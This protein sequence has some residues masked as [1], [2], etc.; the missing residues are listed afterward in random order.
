MT[1][2]VERQQAEQ[3]LQA[4]S[5]ARQG[6]LTPDVV[7]EAARDPESPLHRYFTWDDAEAGSCY[8]LEQARTLIRSVKVVFKVEQRQV[9]APFYVRDPGKKQGQQGYTSLPRLRTDEDAAREVV[10]REFAAASAALERARAVASV[11][12]MEDDIAGLVERLGGLRSRLS[13][14]APEDRRGAA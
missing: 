1:T 14:E 3:A 2:E 12:G 6:L 7:V 13:E 4:L 9:S 10:V 8:R 5:D 11:L